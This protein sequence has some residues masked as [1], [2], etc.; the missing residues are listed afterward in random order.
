MNTI[1]AACIAVF[2][3]T[4]SQFQADS[5][6]DT[7]YNYNESIENAALNRKLRR[8]IINGDVS[9]VESLI[10]QGANLNFSDVTS[11]DSRETPV[12]LAA[13]F[14][15]DKEVRTNR[16]T[17][18]ELLIKSGAKIDGRDQNGYCALNDAIMYGYY[19]A[20]RILL[21]AGADVN[22]VD[23]DG[24]PNIKLAFSGYSNIAVVNP[25]GDN[26]A[27]IIEALLEH[28]GVN[29]NLDT[30][31]RWR[32]YSLLHETIDTG[33]QHA[34]KIVELLIKNGANVNA[35]DEDLNTPLHHVA[36]DDADNH[37]MSLADGIKI[38][39]L[40]IQN[41]TNIKAKN[42]KRK[43]AYHLAKS[44]ELKELL[45]FDGVDNWSFLEWFQSLW[46]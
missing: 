16:D 19:N 36:F 14:T 22:D 23:G 41:G 37:R 32:K 35:L 7:N 34:V 38:A 12:Q 25:G 11:Y 30:S 9:K 46:D 26:E 13:T 20:V 17:I 39:E 8:A 44:N 43:T 28:G 5:T 31:K 27:K 15:S 29:V 45:K 21:N 1:L 24:R 4:I 40:L 6:H 33:T 18:L 42:R 2:L 3:C 10:R